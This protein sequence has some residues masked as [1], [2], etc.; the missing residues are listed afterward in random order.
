MESILTSI[1]KNL[2][3]AEA[4]TSF[5]QDI[6]MHI[7]SVFSIL[8]QVGAGPIDGFYI[9]D[10]SKTWNDFSPDNALLN[11]IK[12]YVYLKVRLLFDPPISSAALEAMNKASEELIWR[13]NVAAD[14]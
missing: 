4:D 10:A 9:E 6:I 7:N 13:I 5:D 14:N 12:S 11:F 3:L 8:A 1:K 2:G